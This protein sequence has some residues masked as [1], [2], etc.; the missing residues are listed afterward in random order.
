MN[1]QPLVGGV[2]QGCHNGLLF[3]SGPSYERVIQFP[4][5]SQRNAAMFRPQRA[6]LLRPASC[7]LWNLQSTV[8]FA[9]EFYA[10][11]QVTD[12]TS[13]E[14]SKSTVQWLADTANYS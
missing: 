12:P 6:K 4:L 11:E 3:G 10:T 2:L 13:V 8:H 1:S 9:H 7:G 5:S 14:C